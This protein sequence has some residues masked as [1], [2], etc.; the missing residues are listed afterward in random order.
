MKKEKRIWDDIL[1]ERDRKIYELTGFGESTALG[2]RPAVLVIDVTYR[3]VGDKPQP[4]LESIKEF[5][6]SCGQA[7]W[8][9]VENIQLLLDAARKRAIPVIY[10]APES[11]PEAANVGA[12][13]RQRTKEDF[14]TIEPEIEKIVKEIAPSDNEV[15]IYK[16]TPSVFFG[17]PLISYLTIRSIDTLIVCGT[18][19]SGCVRA[20]V[21]DA[22]SHG[23]KVALVEE[24]T[25]DRG[26]ASHKINLFDMHQKYANVISLEETLEYLEKI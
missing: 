25:F 24:C 22:F 10:A 1:T 6:L 9:A 5:P 4:I 17:T 8:N 18:S 16:Q 14:S 13:K 2:H 15:V 23:F 21:V 11:R 20:S 12:T 3:F 7:G 19:T 26:E